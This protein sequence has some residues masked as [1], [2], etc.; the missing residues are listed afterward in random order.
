MVEIFA[1]TPWHAAMLKSL[2]ENAGI[3]AF[4]IDEAIG[5]MAPWWAAPGGAGSVK[6]MVSGQDIE[7]AHQVSGP[8]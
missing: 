2:L 5:T 8:F 4:L 6:V 1:G 7:N 3:E